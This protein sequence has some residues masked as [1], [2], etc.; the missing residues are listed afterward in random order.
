M[1]VGSTLRL[2]Q[3][4][5]GAVVITVVLCLIAPRM[6]SNRTVHLYEPVSAV[7][8]TA[9]RQP[10][11]EQKSQRI[12][13]ERKPPP[14]ELKTPPRKNMMEPEKPELVLAPL[15]LEMPK[16]QSATLPIAAPEPRKNE[17]GE[18]GVSGVYDVGVVDTPPRI[19]NFM[20]PHYPARAKGRGIE[21]EVLLRF[22]ITAGGGVREVQIVSAEPAGYFE[23]AARDA[24][25]SWS[26]VAARHHGKNVAVTGEYLLTFTLDK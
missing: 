8:L 25:A 10:E 21:G 26:F 19:K 16:M 2:V 15:Q 23:N 3:A 4:F 20:P 24:V 5:I 9:F 14:M 18:F 1:T 12:E 22:V 6:G 11:F 7:Q 17:A 13:P